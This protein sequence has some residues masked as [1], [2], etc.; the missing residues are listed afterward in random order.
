MGGGRGTPHN[1]SEFRHHALGLGRDM[2][3]SYFKKPSSHLPSLGSVARLLV[4]RVYDLWQ[5]CRPKPN[6]RNSIFGHFE[7]ITPVDRE[8]N[9]ECI[10]QF[11][12]KNMP[13][14]LKYLGFSKL[15][16]AYVI[17]QDTLAK[18]KKRN[19]SHLE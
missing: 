12:N 11:R 19:S 6:K 4:P 1:F 2:E 13:Y 5:F 7:K 18:E 3:R 17:Q 15:K 9:G 10:Y 14:I 16:K 8:S